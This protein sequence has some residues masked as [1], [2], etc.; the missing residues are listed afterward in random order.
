MFRRFSHARNRI[1]SDKTKR[2]GVSRLRLRRLTSFIVLDEGQARVV[3]RI[4]PLACQRSPTQSKL[5]GSGQGS[6]VGSLSVIK[7]DVT[8]M[9]GYS[10][11]DAFMPIDSCLSLR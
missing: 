10:P 4:T 11:N 1:G 7:A 3:C 8:S 9:A 5:P 2:G 6:G